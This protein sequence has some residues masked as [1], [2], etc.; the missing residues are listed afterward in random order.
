MI[1]NFLC[2]LFQL[3]HYRTQHH[4]EAGASAK[5]IGYRFCEEDTVTSHMEQ[6]RKDVGK[7][8]HDDDLAKQREENR[9]FF[10][11]Q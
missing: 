9:E 2:H 7:R 10:L 5:H 6:I 8:N 11:A 4:D 3:R 1:R